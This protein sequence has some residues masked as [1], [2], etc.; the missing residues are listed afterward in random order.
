MRRRSRILDLDDE[1]AVKS[2]F[3]GSLPLVAGSQNTV[4]RAEQSRR[5]PHEVQ[6]FL[7]AGLWEAEI[8]PLF[9]DAGESAQTTSTSRPCNPAERSHRKLSSR[10]RSESNRTIS[11]ANPQRPSLETVMCV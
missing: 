10:M 7:F 6:N 5:H 2:T 11:V 1:E 9:S 3:I 4:A 8:V